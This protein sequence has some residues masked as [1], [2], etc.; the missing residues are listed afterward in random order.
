MFFCKLYSYNFN[1]NKVYKYR[2]KAFIGGG[3]ERE[4]ERNAIKRCSIL[5]IDVLIKIRCIFYNLSY[6][7]QT[8]RIG[9][10]GQNRKFLPNLYID[11]VR[12]VRFYSTTILPMS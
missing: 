12:N 1:L 4:R 5:T 6:L 9:K 8:G 7:A 2:T 3:R 11:S 10:L